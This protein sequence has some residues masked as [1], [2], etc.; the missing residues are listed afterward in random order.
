MLKLQFE[1]KRKETDLYET[2]IQ[3]KTVPA[4]ALSHFKNV[5][6]VWQES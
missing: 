6:V 3:I 5:Y 4:F 2:G 1:L